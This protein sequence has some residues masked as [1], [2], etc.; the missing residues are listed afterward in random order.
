MGMKKAAPSKSGE[1]THMKYIGI[2]LSILATALSLRAEELVPKSIV[3][4]T[5]YPQ[6]AAK[7]R[8]QGDVVIQCF[9]DST[10][11]VMRAEII[12]GPPLFTGQ[13]RENALRWKFQISTLAHDG[14]DSVTLKY[15]YR[16]DAVPEGDG[17][18][19]FM[20]DLPNVIHITIQISSVDR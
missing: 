15:Q 19:S 11:S 16:L 10:G 8:I 12:S 7:A 1:E 6:R 3:A 13:A 14:G 9:I 18:T 4:I 5:E 20:V 17:H 2:A